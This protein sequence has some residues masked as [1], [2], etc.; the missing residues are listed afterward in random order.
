MPLRREV[1]AGLGATILTAC[2]NISQTEQS[3]KKEND[4]KIIQPGDIVVSP[5]TPYLIRANVSQMVPDLQK[6]LDYTKYKKYRGEV[7]HPDQDTL[8]DILDRY[9]PKKVVVPDVFEEFSSQKRVGM[10][11]GAEGLVLFG[12][13][14]IPLAVAN[15]DKDPFV[16]I[17]KRL[18]FLKWRL[19]NSNFFT[20]TAGG[21]K[22]Y[23][24]EDTLRPVGENI[25]NAITYFDVLERQQPF[26]QFN[27]IAHSFGGILALETVRRHVGIINNLVLI[28]S[29]VR[30]LDSSSS[31][32][33][34]AIEKIFLGDNPTNYL[35]NI[36]KDPKYQSDLDKF[37][38]AFTKKGRGLTVIVSENDPIAQKES[39]MIKGA[40][41]VV[42]HKGIFDFLDRSLSLDPHGAPLYS[43]LVLDLIAEII[44]VNLAAA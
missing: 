29:P 22:E 27:V 32:A 14:L 16:D 44:G 34:S 2:S 5:T 9:P 36:W 12:G 11:Y 24:R 18:E 13:I 33:T 10:P 7:H 42:L 21:R 15:L 43:K 8:E 1:L 40:R 31:V 35:F 23:K 39:A 19:Q 20:Y 41:L 17:R 38:E 25:R 28:S 26:V 3:V 4:P 30:G 37:G 6:Y